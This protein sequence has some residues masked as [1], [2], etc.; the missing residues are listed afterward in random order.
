MI[1]QIPL[2]RLLVAGIRALTPVAGEQGPVGCSIGRLNIEW[3][4]QGNF[5]CIRRLSSGAMT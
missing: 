3:P 1:C 2:A 5:L 4:S